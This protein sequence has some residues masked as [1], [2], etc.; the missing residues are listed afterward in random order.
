VEVW[1]TAVYK[2]TV[3]YLEICDLLRRR[4]FSLYSLAGL[5]Y[6]TTD[7]LLWSDAI[8]LRED[9]PLFAEPVTIA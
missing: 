7:R 8:F 5:H 4:G 6:S 2:G 1:F 3:T 9:S